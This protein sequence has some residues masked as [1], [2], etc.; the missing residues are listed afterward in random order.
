M[1]S[2]A[3]LAHPLPVPHAAPSRPRLRVVPPSRRRPRLVTPQRLAGLGLGLVIGFL[4]VALASLPLGVGAAAD[5]LRLAALAGLLAAPALARSRAIART[6]TRATR[7]R[8]RPAA[9]H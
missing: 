2:V 8:R 7:S 5:D 6:R 9:R 1:S 4:L 3:R